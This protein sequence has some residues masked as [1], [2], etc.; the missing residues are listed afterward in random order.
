MPQGGIPKVIKIGE[1]EYN[2]A[3]HPELIALVESAR[4][5]EKDKL[6]S[7][8]NSLKSEI[9]KFKGDA[10]SAEK[11]ETEYKDNLQKLQDALKEKED[12]LKKF[13]GID[14]KNP[15]PKDDP[16]ENERIKKLEEELAK[17]DA[18]NQKRIAEMEAKMERDRLANYRKALL[19]NHAG[20]VIDDFVP[21]TLTSTE[22][23]DKAVAEAV[24]KSKNYLRGEFVKADGTKVQGTLAEIE[25]WEEEAKKA[26]TPPTPPTYVPPVPTPPAGGGGVG[27][28]DLLK[29]VKN[30]T[31][32]Q[33]KANRD[34]IRAQIRQVGLET[35]EE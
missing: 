15:K 30:M 20:K 7:S 4:K 23:I 31:P 25:V 28:E 10:T 16:M 32:E 9:E 6:Y 34:A 1:V 3:D 13:E 2:V 12:A 11:K 33:F 8:I 35:A 22:D 24:T 27:G 21:E 17:K 18:D 14:P 19:V 5:E 29:D 26:P